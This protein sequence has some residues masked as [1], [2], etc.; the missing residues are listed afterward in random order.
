MEAK[1]RLKDEHLVP[2]RKRKKKGEIV[3]FGPKKFVFWN[4]KKPFEKTCIFG[5]LDVESAVSDQNF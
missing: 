3:K 2:G 4:Q 5:L 1:K